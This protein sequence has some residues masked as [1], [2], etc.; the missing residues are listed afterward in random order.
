MLL[1]TDPPFLFLRINPAKLLEI[2]IVIL[3][4]SCN[5]FFFCGVKK[6]WLKFSFGGL[7][8]TF[9]FFFTTWH[10]SSF[11]ITGLLSSVIILYFLGSKTLAFT[12]KVNDFSSNSFLSFL[13]CLYDFKM[14]KTFLTIKFLDFGSYQNRITQLDFFPAKLLSKLFADSVF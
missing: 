4:V 9:L 7:S 13:E 12:F 6:F 5:P 10:Q 1:S 11:S 8:F 14:D 2:L 3:T